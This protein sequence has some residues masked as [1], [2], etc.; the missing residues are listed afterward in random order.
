[1]WRGGLAVER[2]C[3]PSWKWSPSLQ[4]ARRSTQS[5]RSCLSSKLGCSVHGGGNTVM[6]LQDCN[7]NPCD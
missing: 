3:S 2:P 6:A 7:L 4:R 5:W 1:M